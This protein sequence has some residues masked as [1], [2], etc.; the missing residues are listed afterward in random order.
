MSAFASLGS[1]SRG[2]ATCVRMGQALLL[3]DCGFSLRQAE[4]RLGRLGVHPA[5]IDAILVTHEHSDHA[6]GVPALAARYG[7]PLYATHGTLKSFVPDALA[8]VSIGETIRGD[9]AFDLQGVRVTPVTVPHD[10]REPVQFV[11]RHAGRQIGV[12]SDLGCV[13]PHVVDHYRGCHG[14]MLESNHDLQMLMRG[15]YPAHLKRRIAGDLGHLSNSQAREFLAAVANPELRVVIGHVSAQN[16]HP[17]LLQQSFGEWLGRVRSLDYATQQG[18]AA[19]TS[20]GADANDANYAADVND[21]GEANYAADGNDAGDANYA[22]D[23][24]DA[25]DANDA[26]DANDA[27]DANDAG[28]ARGSPISALQLPASDC[29]AGQLADGNNLQSVE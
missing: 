16:N 4:T 17:D 26:G 1:G 10:A 19:W 24:N 13:T 20:V 22:A 8:G 18:G 15:G 27:N 21:A 6:S 7:I 2:N 29:P 23:A 14:L 28:E 5:D 9:R 3:V 11:F 25:N 12:I